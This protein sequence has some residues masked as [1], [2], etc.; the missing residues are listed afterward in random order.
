MTASPMSPPQLPR[1]HRAVD[2]DTVQHVGGLT[3]LARLELR[4][5]LISDAAV[6]LLS[7]LAGLKVL[8]IRQ[9]GVTDAGAEQLANALPECK[10]LR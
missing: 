10:V 6:D 1:S 2:D 7:T 9:T 8:D 5:T 3:S 4:Q